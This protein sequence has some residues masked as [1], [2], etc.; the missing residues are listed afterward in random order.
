MQPVKN[1]GFRDISTHGKSHGRR[2]T[3]QIYFDPNVHGGI[4]DFLKTPTGAWC[5]G[6]VQRDIR[7]LHRCVYDMLHR[8]EHQTRQQALQNAVQAFEKFGRRIEQLLIKDPDH[9]NQA[10]ASVFLSFGKRDLEALARL[11][12]DPNIESR[13]VLDAL[14]E[15]SLFLDIC[16]PG[17]IT[18]VRGALDGLCVKKNLTQA[19]HAFKNKLALEIVQIAVRKWVASGDIYEGNEVHHVNAYLFALRHE[20]NLNPIDDPLAPVSLPP[21]KIEICRN[22]MQDMLANGCALIQ[23]A[24]LYQETVSNRLYEHFELPVGSDLSGVGDYSWLKTQI[25][26]IVQQ[27]SDLIGFQ[28]Q[29]ETFLEMT[30][31]ELGTFSVPGRSNRIL[32]ALLLQCNE[33]GLSNEVTA[34]FMQFNVAGGETQSLCCF[35][36]RGWVET[37]DCIRNS[38]HREYQRPIEL[39]DK[40]MLLDYLLGPEFSNRRQE[41]TTSDVIYSNELLVDL[42]VSL[43]TED[44]VALLAR[45]TADR[46]TED[47]HKRNGTGFA[48]ARQHLLLEALP[49]L[50]PVTH[51]E[52]F[53]LAQIPNWSAETLSYFF[54]SD[55]KHEIFGFL[56]MGCDPELK[57]FQGMTLL[58]N[59]VDAGD[60]SFAKSLISAGC[61]PF[62]FTA[63]GRSLT[64]LL[65]PDMKE[66]LP[67]CRLFDIFS[68]IESRFQYQYIQFVDNEPDPSRQLKLLYEMLLTTTDSD[69]TEHQGEGL[70][71][72]WRQALAEIQENGH[73]ILTPELAFL[74]ARK[75]NALNPF[76]ITQKNA[77]VDP[78][79]AFSYLAK[80]STLQQSA[81][82]YECLMLSSLH[83]PYERERGLVN[84]ALNELRK[85]QY[86]R[87]LASVKSSGIQR[88][89]LMMLY[90]LGCGPSVE[91]LDINEL[92]LAKSIVADFFRLGV[93]TKNYLA[94][95]VHAEICLR[96]H[97]HFK[98]Q[99]HEHDCDSFSK[100]CFAALEA[101]STNA[102][103]WSLVAK[104]LEEAEVFSFNGQTLTRSE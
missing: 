21:E 13:R 26:L 71:Y 11:T 77:F 14:L 1:D 9:V 92:E 46:L 39:S 88:N 84:V 51:Q 80:K 56:K 62:V 12:S 57:D 86:I 90:R 20:F 48:S 49:D 101:N 61:S 8:P 29:P 99:P 5:L 72:D 69:V 16:A 63:D 93:A 81:S 27:S 33:E 35:G 44:E 102:H 40:E 74:V 95:T 78:L 58:Q 66:A 42:F 31:V 96:L 19:L 100:H 89:F 17:V 15:L 41:D 10:D 52:A 68:L 98:T 82:I 6:Q 25:R 36:D 43:K 55:Q 28:I 83:H 34:K 73:G 67:F 54:E 4:C 50:Q 3:L 2:P 47:Q 60:I 32:R 76:F 22:A 65:P 30:D 79:W 53:L 45:Y 104:S 103:V 87:A 75:T 64:D 24:D 37:G 94:G 85:T 91:S 23:L 70:N 97:L 7:D 18:A 59:A 38:R